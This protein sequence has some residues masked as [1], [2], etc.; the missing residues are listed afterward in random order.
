MGQG[1]PGDADGVVDSFL[2]NQGSHLFV[3]LSQAD[4][5]SE[6]ILQASIESLPKQRR[7]SSLVFCHAPD[8]EVSNSSQI[9]C[10]TL[11]APAVVATGGSDFAVI[12]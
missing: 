3:W 8:E 10:M 4:E 9:Q 5:D 6:P 12:F 7:G 2:K 11:Q 1:L